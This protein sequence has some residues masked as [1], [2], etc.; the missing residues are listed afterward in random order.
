MSSESRHRQ[1][2]CNLLAPQLLKWMDG[3]FGSIKFLLCSEKR[4]ATWL[5]CTFLTADFTGPLGRCGEGVFTE[6]CSND[7]ELKNSLEI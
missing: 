2:D 6:G 5:P 3:M 7:K 1:G 4:K